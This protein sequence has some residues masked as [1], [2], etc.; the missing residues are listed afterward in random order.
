MK[1]LVF[2]LALVLFATVAHADDKPKFVNGKLDRPFTLRVPTMTGFN[3]IYIGEKLG[4]YKEVGLDIEY[5]GSM[6]GSMLAQSVIKGDNH[7]F[8]TG[9]V[10]TLAQARQAGAPLKMVLQGS[11][12]DPEPRKIHM[13]YLVREDSPIKTAK[14]VIGKKVSIAYVGSCVELLFSEWLRQNGIKRDQVDWVVMRDSEAENALRLGHIDVAGIHA[15][16]VNTALSRG[17]VRVLVNTWQIGTAAGNGP[18]SSYSSR[19]F[20]ESFITEYPDVIKAYIAA[21]VK[22]Q[23]WINTHYDDAILIAAEYLHVAPEKAGGTIFPSEVAIDPEKVHFW[24]KMM[25]DNGFV[26]PG[27]V[28]DDVW[29]NDYNPYLTGEV[30]DIFTN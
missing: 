19:A 11:Q 2:V 8:G 14:D 22:T 18:A 21:T 27:S 4:F 17:G 26:K 9:H 24:I 5:T 12:D 15:V 29:T 23:H 3:E 13:S 10:L 20:S 16:F 28:S 25:E 7:L 30:V 1:R 6:T